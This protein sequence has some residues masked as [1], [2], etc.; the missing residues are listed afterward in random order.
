MEKRT[1]IIKSLKSYFIQNAEMLHVE[2]A[3]LFGSWASGNPRED[4]DVDIAVFFSNPLSDNTIFKIVNTMSLESTRILKKDVNILPIYKDFRKP[5]L[6][7]NAIV[8]GIPL[9]IE[10]FS[11]F[12]EL[13][14]HAIYQMEDF[15]IFGVKWQLDAA[16]KNI[17]K[18][19]NV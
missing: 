2:I 5:M 15:N 9:Y 1:E 16:R 11:R 8:L 17:G 6:Y 14:L 12:I 3:F 13:K 18:M 10:D 7:Y 4:S 19:E